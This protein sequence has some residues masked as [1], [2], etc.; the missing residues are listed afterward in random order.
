MLLNTVLPTSSTPRALCFFLG[1]LYR[2]LAIKL[3][4]SAT[5]GLQTQAQA[6]DNNSPSLDCRC[7]NPGSQE[8]V[9]LQPRTSLTMRFLITSSIFLFIKPLPCSIASRCHSSSWS[10]WLVPCTLRLYYS[11]HFCYSIRDPG[12]MQTCQGPHGKCSYLQ[13]TYDTTVLF[14][15]FSPQVQ[16]L[17]Y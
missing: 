12:K 10:S 1:I 15:F 16:S 3:F 5:Q 4:L 14:P 13:G 2:I 8:K 9:G 17:R 7:W 6:K 11:V